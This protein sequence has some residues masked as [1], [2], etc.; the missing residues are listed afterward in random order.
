[1]LRPQIAPLI[2]NMKVRDFNVLCLLPTHEADGDEVAVGA[3]THFEQSRW[4][5]LR[6]HW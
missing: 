1:M 2:R 3:M 6:V 4:V 5:W